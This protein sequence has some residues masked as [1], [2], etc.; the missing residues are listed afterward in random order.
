ML[1][2]T[3][4]VSMATLIPLGDHVIVRPALK[5]KATE[6]GII[7]P[8]TAGKERPEQGEIIAVGQGKLLQDGTRAKMSVSVGQKIIFKKYGPDEVK[9]GNEEF[10]VLSESDILA[11]IQ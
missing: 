6:T 11:I 5:E 2:M 8:D 1:G 10:L 4:H 9:V 3:E 7:V